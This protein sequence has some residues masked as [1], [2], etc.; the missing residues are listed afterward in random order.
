MFARDFATRMLPFDEMSV[1]HY[2][3][4]VARRRL[5]GH[6]ISAFDAAILAIARANGAGVATRNIRDFEGCGVLVHDPWQG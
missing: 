4:L 5:A 1:P 6:A 3:D 2:A